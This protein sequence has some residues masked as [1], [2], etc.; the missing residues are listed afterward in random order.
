MFPAGNCKIIP[1]KSA[2]D[3]PGSVYAQLE[4]QEVV[5]EVDTG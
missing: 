3:L 1:R 4:D 2:C 5:R